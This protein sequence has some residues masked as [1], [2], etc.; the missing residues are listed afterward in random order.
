MTS[1]PV[2][3]V[4]ERLYNYSSPDQLAEHFPPPEWF[5]LFKYALPEIRHASTIIQNTLYFPYVK[6]V[7]SA[8]D[9][10]PFPPKVVIFG[11]DPYHSTV[12]GHPQACGMAFSTRKNCPLQPSIRNMYEE[13]HRTYPQFVQ[14]NHGDLSHWAQQGVLLL[15]V[16]LTVKPHEPRSHMKEDVNIWSGFIAKAISSILEAN[17]SCIFLLWGKD[18]IELSPLLGERSIKFIATHPS[19]FSA[20]K[21]SKMASAFIGSGHFKMVNDELVKQGKSPI[22]WQIPL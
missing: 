2:F 6:D 1:S 22:D 4:S 13:I 21:D 15:N 7:F 9:K 18:A 17:P 8:F 20:R 14:P 11:Q 19:G 16:C 10:C 5:T 12:N 3:L